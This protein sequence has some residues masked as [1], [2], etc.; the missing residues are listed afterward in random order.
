MPYFVTDDHV[1][2]YYE[3]KGKG[4]P[5]LLIHG[6]T[7]NRRHFRKQT[8]EL[9]EH[10]R[11]ITL[12]LRG[13]GD[14]E[15]PEHGLTIGRLAQDIRELLDYLEVGTFSAVG[16]SMGTHVIFE[17]VKQFSC[18][19]LEKICVIDMAPKIMKADD[20]SF[21]LPGL[22][23]GQA[24]D[25]GHEDNLRILAAMLGSWD[26]YSRIVAQRILNRSLMNA[27]MEFDDRADF[28]GKA[29][30]PWLYE[31]AKRNTPHV[32]IAFW[33]SMSVQDYRP[34]LS[35]ITAPCLLTYGLESNYYPPENY[36]Y[37]KEMIP[38]ARIVPF[39]DCGHALHI[40]DAAKF[41]RELIAFLKET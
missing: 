29:D 27:K 32:I 3:E 33:I 12:D 22:L 41:N 4:R 10:F 25:F 11:V 30:L 31:E 28:P 5:V 19:R 8:P 26:A 23:N 38:R 7:A 21:G 2:L 9:A 40:Q 14:S 15:V 37:M 6:L 1:R 17:F 36:E 35:Y 20:W 39:A 13:H 18:D 34:Y 16:W 24:G